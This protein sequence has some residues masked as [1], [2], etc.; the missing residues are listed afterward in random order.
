MREVFTGFQWGKLRPL[1]RNR[2]RWEDNIMMD[3]KMGV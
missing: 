1:E 2:S 3:L